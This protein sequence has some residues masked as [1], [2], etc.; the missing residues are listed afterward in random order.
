METVEVNVWVLSSPEAMEYDEVPLEVEFNFEPFGG[1]YEITN[2]NLNN[3]DLNT[4]EFEQLISANRLLERN[5]RLAI[6]DYMTNYE[7]DYEE[8][9]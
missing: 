1:T 7:P 4:K 2:Y 3:K 8:E 6:E 5:I 9:C